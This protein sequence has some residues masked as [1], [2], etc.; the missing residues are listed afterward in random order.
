MAARIIRLGRRRYRKMI[1]PSIFLGDFALGGTY[2]SMA[3]GDQGA[4]LRTD[5]ARAD[6]RTSCSRRRR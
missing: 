2:F 4:R 1:R 5:R 6:R 3:V